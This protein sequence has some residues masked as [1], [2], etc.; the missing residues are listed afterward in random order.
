MTEALMG[1]AAG[2]FVAWIALLISYAYDNRQKKRE[3][4]RQR[5]AVLAFLTREVE[6]H[7]GLFEQLLE[8]ASKSTRDEQAGR[9][10]SFEEAKTGVFE[11]VF[12]TKWHLLPDGVLRPVMEYY[13]EVHS[14]NTV[15]T[16]D[17]A[18]QLPITSEAVLRVIERVKNGAE[19]LLTLLGAQ[20]PPV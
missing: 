4:Q 1:V 12:L 5:A 7:K 6:Y 16:R 20:G 13:S 19:E 3:E 17:F 8:W 11:N 9:L 2:V 14:F 15:L 10:F 18:A